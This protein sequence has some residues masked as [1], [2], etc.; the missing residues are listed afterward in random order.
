[1]LFGS[2]SSQKQ[3]DS[4]LKETTEQKNRLAYDKGRLQSQVTQL[5]AEVTALADT[6]AEA[7]QLNKQREA[8]EAK[9]LK[10]NIGA[11]LL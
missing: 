11:C 6:R 8:M 7:I 4:T 10:V 2:Q 1:M 5:Q 3:L 9:Y